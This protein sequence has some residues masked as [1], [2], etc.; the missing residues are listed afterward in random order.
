MSN[1][2]F[3]A[4]VVVYNEQRRLRDC[5]ES[6]QF[7]KRI[8]VF[9]LGSTDGSQLI[10]EELGAVVLQHE[11]VP[12]V[13]F[14][15]PTAVMLAPSEWIIRADPDE[16]FSPALSSQIDRVIDEIPNLGLI[17]LPHQYYF[18]GKPL[19]STVWG[20]I[21]YS[22]KVF[23]KERV[24]ISQH[25]HQAFSLRKSYV[26]T[27]IEGTLETPVNTI[28]HYWIDSYSQLIEKHRR[29]IRLEGQTRHARGEVFSW[30]RMVVETTHAL[31]FSLIKKRGYNQGFVGAFLSIFWAWYTAKSLLSLRQYERALDYTNKP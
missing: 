19:F 2:D 11:R 10:A 27:C 28:R 25:V 22:P 29:Y 26:S 20:G 6:L 15:L 9:D 21:M 24:D 16:V 18:L 17:H 5:L 4:V 23:H 31:L 8:L 14:V 12:I 30:R 7:C 1:R 3:T 13:E